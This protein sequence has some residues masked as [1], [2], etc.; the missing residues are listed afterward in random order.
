[1]QKWEGSMSMPS[2]D[3]IPFAE[4]AGKMA[5]KMFKRQ[6]ASLERDNPVLRL[7][8]LGKYHIVELLAKKFGLLPQGGDDT[9]SHECRL[10]F[11]TGDLF[12]TQM[13]VILNS[14][15]FK[16]LETQA[17]I[18]FNGV[19]GHSDFIIEMPDGS[20]YLLELK[21]ANSFYFKQIKKWIGDERG[22]LTQLVT[23]SHCLDLPAAWIF[24]NKDTSEIFIKELTDVPQE[25]RDNK[26]KRANH[27]VKAFNE[28]T[29]FE[30]FPRY[31]MVPPP[32][33]EKTKSGEYKYWDD[34]SLR[35]YVGDNDFKKPELFY[36]V[37]RKKND[38]GKLRNYVT[39]FVYPEKYANL[40]P[41]IQESALHFDGR[42]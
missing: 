5:G 15:G 22:Y 30:E 36:V 18:D 6:Y 20:K 37:D 31:C 34:G 21:T 40:K 11:L 17:T 1:M 41:D 25:I 29:S 42:N 2:L 39:D 32:K 27:L 28:C 24:V 9:V 38:Y 19:S 12:E 16:V 4:E 26:L 7:S 35:L 13:Y 33:I 10:R 14:F 8:G 23:Y 3:N